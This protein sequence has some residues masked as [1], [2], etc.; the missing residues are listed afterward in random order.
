MH[1]TEKLGLPQT[2]EELRAILGM[3]YGQGGGDALSQIHDRLLNNTD[4]TEELVEARAEK[5]VDRI[6]RITVGLKAKLESGEDT[7]E[8]LGL[9]KEM[10]KEDGDSVSSMASAILDRLTNLSE[11]KPD[12]RL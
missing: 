8:E 3:A 2:V 7:S 9:I 6:I 4:I 11:G 10:Q 12:N 1:I 5:A